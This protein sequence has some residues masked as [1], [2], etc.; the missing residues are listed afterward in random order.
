MDKKGKVSTSI[1]NGIATIAFSHPKSN[2]LSSRM[3]K[4]LQAQLT[5]LPKI[6]TYVIVLRSE[7]EKAFCAGASF[8][9]LLEIKDF[10]NGKEF[11]MGFARLI[12][13]MRKCPQFII[14][15]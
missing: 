4:K 12:N 3:V 7:G 10:K 14:A 13:A 8:D 2:S 15:R 6:N 5:N 1:I 9:E 11:F